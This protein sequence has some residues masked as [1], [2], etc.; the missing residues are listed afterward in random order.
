MII[1]DGAGTGRKAKVNLENQIEAHIAMQ[2]MQA[3]VAR[4]KK[5]AYTMDI[6]N[7]AVSGAHYF[8]AIKNTDDLDMVVTSVTLWVNEFKDT[9]IVEASVGG[10]FTYSA[11]GTA[12]IPSNCDAASGKAASGSFYVNDGVGELAT[13]TAGDITGRHIFTTTPIKWMKNSGW[14]I[15]KNLCFFLRVE[16][17]IT[18]RGYVSFYYHPEL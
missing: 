14:V 15:P 5:E 9:A 2:Y 1:E 11:N 4:E 8:V 16:G 10:T 6:D 17:G 12:V 7:V 3:W 18:F 13:I